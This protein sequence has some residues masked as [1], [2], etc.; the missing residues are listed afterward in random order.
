MLK[1]YLDS[2]LSA[3]IKPKLTRFN[4]KIL[5]SS[6]EED[7][8]L[9]EAWDIAVLSE[10]HF[11]TAEA[12]K[13]MKRDFPF[14]RVFFVP[15][16][17]YS[18]NIHREDMIVYSEENTLVNNLIAVIGM[19]LKME[20]Y[21]RRSS[22][23]SIDKAP[24]FFGPVIRK[25]LNS[26]RLK[27][28]NPLTQLIVSEKGIDRNLFARYLYTD[29]IMDVVDC[30]EL[31]KERLQLFI[32]GDEISEGFMKRPHEAVFIDNIQY[33]DK[34]D[35]LYI[36]S[37][38]NQAKSFPVVL[39]CR[40]EELEKIRNIYDLFDVT[41]VPPMRMRRK[42]IPFVLTKL[43]G[44]IVQKY[45][46]VPNFPDENV[47][48]LC[49]NYSWP[50]NYEELET[51]AGIFSMNGPIEAIKEVIGGIEEIEFEDQIPRMDKFQR[52]LRACTEELLVRKAME[53]T[54]N[55]RKKAASILGI[56]YKSLSKKLK[57][58]M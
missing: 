11:A 6:S 34:E 39:G 1:V 28:S 52:D 32:E 19:F 13:V 10:S 27:R 46:C 15:S 31:K 24:I 3:S 36:F 22:S 23:L 41:E 20:Y 16:T 9:S 7:A 17:V 42:D 26:F 21:E 14:C 43:I 33:L 55:N 49:K 30:G 38:A 18:P 25:F 50:G 8:K 54:Q 29:L 5:L 12:E 57:M 45:N 58:Y 47:V 4:K 56:S 37:F 44:D 48:R 40:K 2:E 51:F 53:T 35:Q